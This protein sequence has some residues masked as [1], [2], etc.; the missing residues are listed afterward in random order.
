[1]VSVR[2]AQADKNWGDVNKK[3]YRC[4]ISDKLATQLNKEVN[5][6]IRVETD[7]VLNGYYQDKRIHGGGS[8]DLRISRHEDALTRLNLA[9]DDTVEVWPTVPMDDPREA[10]LRGD[11]AETL[12]QLAGS[13]VFISCPHGGDIEYNTDEMGMYLAKKLFRQGIPSTVWALHGYYSGQSKDAFKRWHVK[14]PIKGYGAYPGLRKLVEQD[15]RFRYGVGFHIHSADHVAVGGMADE[16]I[17]ESI[18]TALRSPVPSKYDIIT[19]YS[20]MSLT[21]K[22]TKMSMNYFAADNQGIQ[23]EMPRRIA[24]KKFHTVPKAVAD[25]FTELL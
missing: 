20:D 6:H 14:K 1:M 11:I 7:G 15:R 22:G 24:H 21:G 5:G 19:E 4:S 10:F 16:D 23:I 25:V 18:A 17:R 9:V 2:V 12:W 8:A 13:E 3:Y